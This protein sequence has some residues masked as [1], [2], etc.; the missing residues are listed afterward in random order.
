MQI[1]SSLQSDIWHNLKEPGSYEWWYFDAVT[2]DERYSIVAIWFSGFPF[3][4]YYLQRLRAWKQNGSKLNGV[5]N[6]SK[7]DPPLPNP[8]EHTAFSLVFMPMA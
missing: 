2:D 7:Y 8:L 5:S 4:P 1:L 3:S 6:G